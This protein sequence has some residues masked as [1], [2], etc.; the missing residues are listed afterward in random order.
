FWSNVVTWTMPAADASGIRT[1]ASVVGGKAHLTVLLPGEGLQVGGEG[2]A[3]TWPST[4]TAGIIRPDGSTQV[5]PLQATA[6]GQY[7]GEVPASLP[8]PYLVKLSAGTKR[9]SVQL[10][11]TFLVAP[12]SPEFATGGADPG[13]MK[14]LAKAG[15]GQEVTD[16]KTAF[17]RN[18]P[19]APGRLPLDQALLM[20][21]LLL[22][23]LDIALRRLA[24][25]LK[26]V[27]E[28][29]KRRR[30]RVEAAPE[31]AAGMA[32]GRLRERRAAAKQV[33]RPAEPQVERRVERPAGQPQEPSA[34]PAGDGPFTQRLLDA[35]RKKR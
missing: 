27:A 24:V 9:Q 26:D 8:G 28:A 1:V 35:K 34:A 11:E 20:L 33:E 22:W 21:A 12:Y 23:P 31:T 6:P 10:G 17:A 15:G 4:L 3:G 25:N 18:L 29:V 7:E 14:G 32:L 5:M 13:F 2:G 16:P 19:P 30:N